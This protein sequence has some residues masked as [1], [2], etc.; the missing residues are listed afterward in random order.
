MGTENWVK[1]YLDSERRRFT[2]LLAS[3]TINDS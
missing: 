1:S 2:P 3:P